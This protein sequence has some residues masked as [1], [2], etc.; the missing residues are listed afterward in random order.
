MEFV[1]GTI[2]G[3]IN[4]TELILPKNT[5]LGDSLEYSRDFVYLVMEGFVQTSLVQSPTCVNTIY[6]KGA[7]LN[8]FS[9]LDQETQPFLF[10]TIS[11]CVIYK[12]SMK[13]LHYFL[14]MFPENYG[15]QFFI[16][17]D[18][19][20]HLYYRTQLISCASSDK[21]K[22]S[23][24]NMARLHGMALGRDKVIIP[25]TIQAPHIISYSSL[26]RS[27]G[28]KQL[29]LLKEKGIVR[30]IEDQWIVHNHTLNNLCEKN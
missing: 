14:A 9:L 16:M 2:K 23:F 27:S 18:L 3:D 28:Y 29:A 7:F 5:T 11:D 30:Q 13:D 26:S 25:Q 6:S 19:A 15:F 17:K 20:A 21:L 1:Q 24:Q 8:Y 10:K 12:Y 22:V 4:Y